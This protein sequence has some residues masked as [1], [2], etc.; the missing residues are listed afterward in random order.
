ME[1]YILKKTKDKPC[2]KFESTNHDLTQII[3]D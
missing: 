3:Q 2:N 1:K